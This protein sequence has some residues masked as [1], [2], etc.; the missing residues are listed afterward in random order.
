MIPLRIIKEA[1]VCIE[2]AIQFCIS[3][4][5]S[6]VLSTISKCPL[7]SFH[8]LLAIAGV[9]NKNFRCAPSLSVYKSVH[10][11]VVTR[12]RLLRNTDSI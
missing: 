10:K 11:R 4:L 2:I 9:G 12:D 8:S 7:L 1:L 5:V 3:E 6:C